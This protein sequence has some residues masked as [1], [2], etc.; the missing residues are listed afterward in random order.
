MAIK[1]IVCK[2]DD[3]SLHFRAFVNVRRCDA[4]EVL[5]AS[6][7]HLDCFKKSNLKFSWLW[8]TRSMPTS[9]RNNDD[10]I[11]VRKIRVWV[12][13]ARFCWNRYGLKIVRIRV[14]KNCK[15]GSNWQLITPPPRTL[16]SGRKKQNLMT[17][18]VQGWFVLPPTDSNEAVLTTN[19][20]D[21]Y[22]EDTLESR[23]SPEWRVRSRRRPWSRWGRSVPGRGPCW[24]RTDRRLSSK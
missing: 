15:N 18:N 6:A 8:L 22:P 9:P 24:R 12:D 5:L 11:E 10:R 19:C 1:T 4:I 20:T 2:S 16:T 14:R 17:E 23:R 21:T 13:V 3:L 7:K